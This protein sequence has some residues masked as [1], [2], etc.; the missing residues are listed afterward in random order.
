MCGIA[1]ERQRIDAMLEWATM[2]GPG[3]DCVNENELVD[4]GLAVLRE[5]YADTCSEESMRE[6]CK[7][8]VARLAPHQR[9]TAASRLDV[10]DGDL[11]RDD[12][13]LLTLRRR[14]RRAF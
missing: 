1:K 5:H 2:H 13:G 14:F 11:D 12:P 4:L 7:D 10:A 9:T 3:R 6:R 8:F